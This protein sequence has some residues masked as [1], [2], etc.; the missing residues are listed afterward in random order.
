M[1]GSRPDRPM[2][3]QL[4]V[5]CRLNLH[6][7]TN[8]IIRQCTQRTTMKL[9]AALWLRCG[10]VTNTMWCLVRAHGIM[11]GFPM[12]RTVGI[13]YKL[14]SLSRFAQANKR[15]RGRQRGWRH[16]AAA[17]RALCVG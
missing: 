8:V 15:P 7:R 5:E 16:T 10:T 1:S 3:A 14:I 4:Q 6:I 12:L 17:S 11:L 2:G 9:F 13:R